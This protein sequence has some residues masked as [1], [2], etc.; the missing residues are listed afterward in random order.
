MTFSSLPFIFYFLPLFFLLYYLLPASW[1]QAALL[2][3]SLF[4]CAWGSPRGMLLL[5]ALIGLDLLLGRYLAPGRRRARQ[6]LLLG[7]AILLNLLPLLL[8]KYS[9]FMADS[10]SQLTGLSLSVPDWVQPLGLSFYTFRSISY[11]V[12][13]WRADSKPAASFLDLA[14]YLAFFPQLLS[15]PIVRYS[16]WQQQNLRPQALTWLRLQN[17]CRRMVIGLAKKLLLADRLA[18]V[19]Q[20][21]HQVNPG[22]LSALTAWIGAICF[23]L[24]I[25]FDFSAYSDMAIGLTQL[26]G[27][28]SPENFLYPYVACSVTDFWRRWHISLSFWFRRYVYIPLGG[29][30]RGRLRQW[31]NILAVWAL[32]GLWHGAAWNYVLWGLYYAALLLLEKQL[33][34]RL[35]LPLWPARLVV[36]LLN[37]LGW[38]FFAHPSL[39]EIPAY[40]SAML[41]LGQAGAADQQGLYLLLTHGL[42]ILLGFIAATPYPRQWWQRLAGLSACPESA[43]RGLTPQTGF[44]CVQAPATESTAAFWRPQKRLAAWLQVTGLLLLLLASLAFS[45]ES[46]F[47]TF[48]YFQF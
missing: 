29:N 3:G 46:S 25:Y 23:S 42:L 45:V 14:V 43:E 8:F 47:S 31:L 21:V 2:A 5:L 37:I 13:V 17:G 34:P 18:A 36:L 9:A 11:L 38:V 48:L 24:Q 27:Y 20:T 6:R 4:F 33:A 19:W 40:F 1:R 44:A 7:A 22:N 15:G 35:K 28:D 30:R 41:G 39:P 10:V 16:W 12:D 32:T 26:L